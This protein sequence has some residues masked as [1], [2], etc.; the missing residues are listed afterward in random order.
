MG[1]L[2]SMLPKANVYK[3]WD[4]HWNREHQFKEVWIMV[5]YLYI[6]CNLPFQVQ[7]C[8]SS[9]WHC[10]QRCVS[11]C[12]IGETLPCCDQG[13]WEFYCSTMLTVFSPWRSRLDLKSEKNSWDKA[14]TL[15]QFSP[16][17]LVLIKNMNLWYEC[18]DAQDDF[19]AQMHNGSV[20]MPSW[21]D[22]G[23]GMI[24]NLDQIAIHQEKGVWSWRNL[25]CSRCL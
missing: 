19:H 22:Q 14:F 18:L 12:Y 17:Q 13:D 24:N 7:H 15:Y 4:W 16:H 23:M 1:L 11:V 8:Q 3:V 20:N 10:N 2:Q 21:A 9:L 5:E 6:S 25:S